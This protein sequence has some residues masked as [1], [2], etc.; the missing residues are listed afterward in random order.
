MHSGN[1]SGASAGA[2]LVKALGIMGIIK[3]SGPS[4]EPMERHGS[5]LESGPGRERRATCKL[6]RQS[7]GASARA[8]GPSVTW[9][10]ERHQLFL[11]KLCHWQWA[12]HQ[13]EA[14]LPVGNCLQIKTVPHCIMMSP[15]SGQQ[16]SPKAI[17]D[18]CRV[19]REDHT[20]SGMY[21]HMCILLRNSFYLLKS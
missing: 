16:P 5:L 7:W 11:L 17:G 2:C 6:A 9:R 10:E 3:H 21:V 12:W 4:G 19:C 8:E 18:L 15:S 1:A 20:Q 13:K 14:S